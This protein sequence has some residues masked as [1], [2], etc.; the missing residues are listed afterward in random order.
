MEN[1]LP[2]RTKLLIH[3][4]RIS[5]MLDNAFYLGPDGSLEGKY[6]NEHPIFI[7]Y[8]LGF[9]LMGCLAYLEGKEGNYGWTLAEY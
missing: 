8:S 7:H 4:R 6:K 3:L 5:T 9:Y 1:K 2:D